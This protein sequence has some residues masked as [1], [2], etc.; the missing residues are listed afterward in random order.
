MGELLD[1]LFRLGQ[2]DSLSG[3]VRSAQSILVVLML[4]PAL[5]SI[6]LMMV[7]SS[8]YHAVITHMKQVSRLSPLI[9]DELLIGLS[10]IVVGRTRF[11]DGEQYLQLQQ[12][13]DEMDA[14]IESDT[15]S[16]MELEVAKR[17]LNTLTRYVNQLGDQMENDASVDENMHLLEEIRSVG[18]LFIELLNDAINADIQSASSASDHMQAVITTTLVIEILLLLITLTFAFFA[19]QSLSRSIR[20]PIDRLKLF[21]G[22]IA[23]GE[24]AERAEQPN[25]AELKELTQSLNTMAEKLE[26]LIHENNM[27]QQ[28]LKMSELRALQAQITPHFLYNTLDAIIW[29]A[30]SKRTSEVVQITGALSNFFRTSLNN[31]KDWITIEQE[32]EHLLGYLTIQRVRYRDILRFEIEV[33]PSIKG[34]R[35]LKLLIQ[36]LVENAIYHGIKNKRGGGIVKVSISREADSIICKVCDNGAG[37]TDE[38]LA[39]AREALKEGEPLGSESGY[40]LFS[41]D[42][43]IKL[44]YNQPN[45]LNLVSVPGEGTTVSFRVPVKQ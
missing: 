8:Q 27:E 6:I 13:S 44:Y 11:E 9:R 40:G 2:R 35:F 3:R 37:M 36:P 42:Q 28:N 33:D 43:R 10:D 14:L 23:S 19:Q 18:A 26:Q 45:G 16:R 12:A 17:A 4:I 7:F 25:A 15:G 22:R 38:Q 41:V 20:M 31:G 24:L 1:K 39:R 34:Q 21:A 32:E 5:V 30:E 29:L